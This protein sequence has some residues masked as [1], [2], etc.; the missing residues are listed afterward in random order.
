[1]RDLCAFD[2]FD[3]GDERC[4]EL[5]HAVRGVLDV[6]T[7]CVD[8]VDRPLEVAAGRL[9]SERLDVPA[10]DHP[11]G[12]AVVDVADEVDEALGAPDGGRCRRSAPSSGTA[13]QLV[14]LVGGFA[15]EAR[16]HPRLLRLEP[17]REVTLQ[18]AVDVRVLALA[19]QSPGR[20]AAA[21]PR[22]YGAPPSA[23]ASRLSATSS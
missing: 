14:P 10:R 22:S 23:S 7:A 20:R 13:L 1:M 12:A 19:T 5:P 8:R 4:G 21:P 2:L 15:Q 11:V 18:P 9:P 6:L 16:Q 17:D 3:E